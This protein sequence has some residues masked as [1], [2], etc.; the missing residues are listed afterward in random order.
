MVTSSA[1]G[2]LPVLYKANFRPGEGG[3]EE[4]GDE[5]GETGRPER[6]REGRPRRVASQ[7]KER[8]WATTK[9]IP[10]RCVR[11]EQHCQSKLEDLE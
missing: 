2:V 10:E 1:Q 8:E 5:E 9:C 4:R 6:E 11:G 3:D 7:D